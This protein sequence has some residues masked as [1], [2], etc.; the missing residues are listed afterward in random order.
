MAV[1]DQPVAE[2]DD[3]IWTWRDL[4]VHYRPEL[5]GAGSRLADAFVRFVREDGIGPYGSAFEWCGGPG[6]IG[7]ALLAEGLCQRLTLSDVNP[8]AVQCVARTVAD[9]GLADRVG[10][11][12]GDNLAPLPLSE[13]FDLVVSNPPNFYD[14]NTRHPRGAA[15]KH[16]LRPNDPQWRL[17]RDFYAGIHRHLAPGAVL[18]I[19]EVEPDRAEVFIPRDEPQPYDVRPRPASD[20]F[21][22]MIS[23]GGLRHVSTTHY[24]TGRDGAELLMMT[25]RAPA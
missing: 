5:D 3:L 16:D 10:V 12:L 7:F 1:S 4:R 13:R 22:E 24:F 8:A 14:L 15:L 11:Y 18:H 23:G 21:L 25:S 20:D 6:F 17:H 19:S 2:A 9:N